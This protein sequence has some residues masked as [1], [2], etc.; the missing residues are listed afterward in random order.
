LFSF[1]IFIELD[2]AQP[3]R[4]SR[5]QPILSNIFSGL[6]RRLIAAAAPKRRYATPLPNEQRSRGSDG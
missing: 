6:A 4:R 1:F 3:L 5:V 2:I